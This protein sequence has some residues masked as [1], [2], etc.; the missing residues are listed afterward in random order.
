MQ[1]F[2]VP[3]LVPVDVHC[4]GVI[5]GQVPH[6]HYGV[7]RRV[8][9]NGNKPALAWEKV[10]EGVGCEQGRGVWQV[11]GEQEIR[12]TERVGVKFYTH[13]RGM[14]EEEASVEAPAAPLESEKGAAIV[15][16]CLRTLWMP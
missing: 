11:T 7:E 8:I 14:D 6:E 13:H 5:P 3:S 12:A 9:V 2:S 10:K 1:L 16:R 4:L 15:C